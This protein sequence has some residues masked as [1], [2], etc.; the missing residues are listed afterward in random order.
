VHF[1]GN[2]LAQ[3]PKGSAEM[4][5]AA[6]RTIFAQPEHVREQL[7]TIA[8][9]LRR[10]LPTVETMLRGAADDITAFADFPVPHWKKIWSTNP[11][12]RLTK[13]QASY[14]R[15][16]RVPQPAALLRLAGSVLVEDPS[17]CQAGNTVRSTVPLARPLRRAALPLAS[18]NRDLGNNGGS[19]LGLTRRA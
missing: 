17:A 9:M 1:L 14:R 13:G 16:R 7:D 4:V 18:G 11:L 12:E 19:D 8:G 5:A 15:C 6:V 3:V 10:Q 2:M